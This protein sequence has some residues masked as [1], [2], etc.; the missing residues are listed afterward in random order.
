MRE[1]KKKIDEFALMGR[2]THQDEPL[3]S[4]PLLSFVT[5]LAYANLIR[6]PASGALHLG[7]YFGMMKPAI[8]LQEKGEASIS[9][10]IIIR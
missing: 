6:H 9:S 5:I 1:A 10:L 3:S 8:E 4:F 7:N 2:T